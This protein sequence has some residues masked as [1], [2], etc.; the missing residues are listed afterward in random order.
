MAAGA[1]HVM[2]VVMKSGVMDKRVSMTRRPE[3]PQD[4]HTYVRTESGSD[5]AE[6]HY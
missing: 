6:L 5:G 1:I 2:V 3:M 4:H